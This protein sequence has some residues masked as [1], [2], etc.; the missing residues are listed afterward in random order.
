MVG[1]KSTYVKQNISYD[2]IS[3]LPAEF[4]GLVESHKRPET[5]RVVLARIIR[6][7]EAGPDCVFDIRTAEQQ[8]IA[9]SKSDGK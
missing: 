6:Q 3:F 4:E 1:V 2:R 9:G 8:V 5:A 7:L